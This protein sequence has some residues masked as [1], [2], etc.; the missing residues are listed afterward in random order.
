MPIK[1]LI[2]NIEFQ[3]KKECEIY[4]KNILQKN[5]ITIDDR[6]FIYQLLKMHPKW[7]D[8]SKNIIK[9]NYKGVNIT[10]IYGNNCFVILNK[11]NT[12]ETISYHKCLGKSD[13]VRENVVS[14]LRECINI[15]IAEYKLEVFLNKNIVVCEL[16]NLELIN[17]SETHVDHINKFRDI[18]N[19]FFIEN[20]IL[21]DEIPI[22]KCGCVYRINDDDLFDKW[23]DYHEKNAKLRLLCKQCNLKIEYL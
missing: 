11:D 20:N 18:I 9:R 2:N 1:Y 4:I 3:S 19:N 21:I 17:N 22:K 10:K 13:N 14:A 6:R 23:Y 15:Q 8:K 7:H 16:C 12:Y 5:E